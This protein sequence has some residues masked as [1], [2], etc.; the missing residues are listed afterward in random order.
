MRNVIGAMH[1]MLQQETPDDY[2]VSTGKNYSVREFIETAFQHVGIPIRWEGTGIDE[3]GIDENTG[4]ILVE[5]DPKYF[6]PTEVDQLLGD[7]SYAREKL[8]WEPEI[9][10]QDLVKE[11]MECDLSEN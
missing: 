4:K 8:G 10:F 1:L 2:V 6:R 3:V 5:I 9:S 11:M 7:S